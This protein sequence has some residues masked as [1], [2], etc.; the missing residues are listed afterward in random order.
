LRL[1]FW[2]DPNGWDVVDNIIIASGN[3]L[4][5]DYRIRMTYYV[6]PQLT[7][8]AGATN[9][10]GTYDF[11][12][13]VNISDDWHWIEVHMKRS[14]GP[15]ND[16]GFVK[17]WIDTV[18]E[19]PD[20]QLTGRDDDTRDFDGVAVGATSLTAPLS[21]TLYFDDIRA[22][23][24]GDAIGPTTGDISVTPNPSTAVVVTVNP[25][26]SIAGPPAAVIGQMIIQNSGEMIVRG[27][28]QVIV[29]STKA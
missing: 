11:T 10:G 16:D 21:E 24:T 29:T 3:S 25:T 17:L 5:S 12:S 23:D 27:N 13:E 22:N 20:A 14:T 15:G 26:V 28:G 6:T 8:K 9:D 1:G 4:A 2:F 18:D 7:I 19:T